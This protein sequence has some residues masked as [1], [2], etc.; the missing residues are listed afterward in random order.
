MYQVIL[1][2]VKKQRGIVIYKTEDKNDIINYI[3]KELPKQAIKDKLVNEDLFFKNSNDY[4]D[5]E[6]N[7]N[8]M[9]SIYEGIFESNLDTAL[10]TIRRRK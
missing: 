4:I 3:E 2:N 6:K 5:I 10:Q 9:C 8:D 1:R 7:S